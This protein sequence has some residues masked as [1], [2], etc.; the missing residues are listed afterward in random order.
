MIYARDELSSGPRI[1]GSVLASG[2]TLADIENWPD[3]VARVTVEDVMAAARQVLDIRRS[4]TGLLLPA[5]TK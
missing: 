2:Y 3:E 4:V 1:L 5:E